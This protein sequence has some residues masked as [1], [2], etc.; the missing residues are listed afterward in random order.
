MAS[1]P[2]E[3]AVEVALEQHRAGQF[4]RAEMLYME[5]LRQD[6]GNV[7]AIHLLGVLAHQ[8]RKPDIAVQ[9]IGRAIEKKPDVPV[10]HYNLAEALVA[11]GDFERAER[12]Y[13]RAIEIAPD[14][15]EAQNNLANLLT[16][17]GRFPDAEAVCRSALAFQ[18]GAASALNNLGN[19][20]RPQGRVDEAIACYRQAVDARPDFFEALN[21]LGMAL[22]SV[23]Q[24]EE[25]V[26]QFRRAIAIRPTDADVHNNL[27]TALIQLGRHAE[28]I[29]SCKMAIGLNASHAEAHNNLGSALRGLGLTQNAIAEYEIAAAARPGFI[30][31]RRN[32]AVVLN[33]VG[34]REEALAAIDEVL[35]LDPALPNEHF[36]RAMILRDLGRQDESVAAMRKTLELEPTHANALTAVGYA[37]LEQGELDAAMDALRR[38]VAVRPDPQAH[39]NMLMTI[40]YHPGFSPAELLRE[41]QA[42]AELHEK[43]L[44]AGHRPH[45]NTRQPGRRLRIGYVS[46]DFRA[47]SVS[48]FLEPILQHHDHSQFEI[49]GYAHITSPDL[50]TWRLRAQID[51]WREV[52]N[53]NPHDIA[54]M[55]RQDGIDILVDLA[56]HTGNN[57]L[58]VF[59]R[60]PA[61]VQVNMIGFP[62]TTGLASMDYRISDALCDPPGESDAFS[63]ER[64][65]RLPK[66]FWAYLPPATAPDV[67]ELPAAANG[68]VTF[69]SVNNFTKITPHVLTA[70]S[71][72][73]AGVPGSRLVFQATAVQSRQVRDAVHRVFD[74]AGVDR[75][76]LEFRA[77]TDL[78]GYLGLLNQSDLTLDPFPFNG[79]TTTCHSLWMGAPVLTLAGD[80]HA[81]R[82]GLSILTNAGLSEFIA[83]DA[84][85]YVRRG[86][87]L[88]TDTPRLAAVRASLRDRLS[89]SPLLDGKRFTADLEAAYRQMWHRWCDSGGA[90]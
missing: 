60:R 59:A 19:A 66:T 65:V 57:A 8:G 51:Q 17:L 15:F 55:I 23:W 6:P 78:A 71:K 87:A 79:G 54:E 44:L 31:P 37:M 47:H 14:Y 42:F 33:D 67:G 86:I 2:M 41:H 28:A 36:L 48:Y 62:S 27:G 9:L 4:A 30:E 25:G 73:L 75:D 5:I 49:F 1:I 22:C 77:W 81:A 12:A 7:D 69:S 53:R 45:T 20:V 13:R 38:S 80:R 16:R 89:Q 34:R 52:P 50:S 3:K 61:P 82:M 68:F 64:I 63:T 84:D 72:I 39:S 70:W 88:A 90:E 32:L 26:T 76:R 58:T 24:L 43:P 18:P 35:T 29:D 11:V 74:A 10:F 46:P 21:N 85:D 56:G 40:N 83:T